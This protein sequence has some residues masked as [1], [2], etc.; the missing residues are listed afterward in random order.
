MYKQGFS[1]YTPKKSANYLFEL[2]LD[3]NKKLLYNEP[4]RRRFSEYEQYRKHTLNG[5]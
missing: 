5:E 3:K 1:L 2:Y 4:H